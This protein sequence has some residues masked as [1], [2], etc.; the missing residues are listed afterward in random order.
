ML[1]G[2]DVKESRSRIMGKVVDNRSEKTATSSK[3][4]G[5][6][7][8]LQPPLDKIQRIEEATSS[9]IVSAAA[10]ALTSTITSS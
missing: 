2:V 9:Q 3:D 6:S 5:Q 1:K 7:R 8:S 10:A 4:D